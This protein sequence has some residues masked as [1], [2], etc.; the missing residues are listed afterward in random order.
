MKTHVIEEEPDPAVG[1]PIVAPPPPAPPAER[2]RGGTGFIVSG[3][4]GLILALALLVGGA[5]VL[6]KYAD[7][8]SGGYLMSGEHRIATPSHALASERLDI[9]SQWP[10]G[11]NAATGRVQAR[12]SVPLFVGIG[13]SADVERYL[14]GVAHAEITDVDTDPFRVTSHLV[15]GGR[16]AGAPGDQGFWQAQ[17]SGPGAQAVNWPVESGEW[18][19]VVMNADGTPGVDVQ[20]RFGARVPAIRTVGIGLLIGGGIA[21][22]G[23]ALLMRR[24]YQRRTA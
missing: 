17:A 10:F 4:I 22:L 14:G 20:A 16:P 1:R 7:R 21:L 6:L 19:V 2:P 8:D 11:R 9:G 24:G 23:G 5:A 12:S 13:R 18:S 3:A 15:D